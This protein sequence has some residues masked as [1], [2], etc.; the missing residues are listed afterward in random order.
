[1]VYLAWVV[2]YRLS[3]HIGTFNSTRCFCVGGQ[4]GQGSDGQTDVARIHIRRTR[5]LGDRFR[6]RWGIPV[7]PDSQADRIVLLPFGYA[8]WGDSG[9][10]ARQIV[11]EATTSFS[12]FFDPRM[13]R[14]LARQDHR[15]PQGKHDSSASSAKL[16]CTRTA[17]GEK[18]V[19]STVLPT[20]A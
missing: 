18:S 16:R 19:A 14:S 7:T 2:E 11:A 4:P 15:R 10:D 6:G 1:M 3:H 9:M 20:Y 12:H 8:C 17:T 13:T 5:C